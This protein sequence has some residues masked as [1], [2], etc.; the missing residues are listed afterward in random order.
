MNYIIWT[1]G[2][3]YY[4]FILL[5]GKIRDTYSINI[6]LQGIHVLNTRILYMYRVHEQLYFILYVHA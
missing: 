3:T 1:E 5:Q 2:V 4:V 6:L